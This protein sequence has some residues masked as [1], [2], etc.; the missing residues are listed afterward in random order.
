MLNTIQTLNITR[1]N[2]NKSRNRAMTFMFKSLNPERHHILAVQEPWRNLQMPTTSRPPNY[3]LIY[4]VSKETRVCF[5]VSKA[6]GHKKWETTEH[7]PG[8]VTL[9]IHLDGRTL[10]IHSCYNPPPKPLTS[11]NLAT[12]QLL[13]QALDHPGEHL[14]IGDF[15]LHHPL[16]G[17]TMLPTQHTLSDILIETTVQSNLQLILPQGTVTWRSGNSMSTLHLSFAT[18]GITEQVL[19]CQLCE[20]LDSD[21]DHVPIITS[22]ETLVPQQTECP[23]QPQWRKANWEKVCKRLKHRLEGLNQEH[24][25]DFGGSDKRQAN[26]LEALDKRVVLLQTVIQD[27]VR[28]TIPLANPSR[29]VRTGWSDECTETVKRARRARRKWVADGSHETYVSYRQAVNERKRQ[30]KRDSAL[31]WRQTVADIMRNPAKMWRLTKWARTTAQEPPPPLQ[32]PPIK[33]RDGRHHSSNEAKANILA[34]HFFPPPVRVDLADTEGYRYPPELSMSQEVTTDEI[35]SIL[36]TIAPDKAPGPDSIPNR[37]LRECRDVLAEPL[38]KL[39]QVCLQSS[40]HPTPFRHSKTVVLIKLQKPAH[41]V[42]KVCRPIALLNTLGKVLEEIFAWRMSALAEE[43][44]LLPTTQMGA[45][46][47]RSTVTALE[48]LT[49][50]IRT[51]W[52]NDTTLVVSMLSLDISGAFDNVSHHRLIHNIRDGRLPHWVAEYIRSFLTDRT[53]TLTL[54]TCEDRVRST[55]SG[56]PQG[57]TLSPILFLFFASTLLP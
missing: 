20:E 39:F 30:I 42:A 44:H 23:A 15:N 29:W 54:G 57:S 37:F 35:S 25:N 5:Y 43:H 47:G 33:D 46:P 11:R 6:I 24:L 28:D 26:D 49:E 53:T 3:H 52:G 10:H 4:L 55:T 13:P 27:T 32:F 51:V 17:G 56:I 40:Y 34:D 9:T 12:L 19:Q 22:I 7:S 1:L 8:L 48:M 21:S 50:Q 31:G 2:M 36:K 41:D 18:S 38:A 16:W 45:R 14:L